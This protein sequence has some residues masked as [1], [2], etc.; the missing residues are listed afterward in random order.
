MRRSALIGAAPAFGRVGTLLAVVAPT[1]FG[2]GCS[3]PTT[4]TSDPSLGTAAEHARDLRTERDDFLDIAAALPG[5]AGLSFRRDTVVIHAT[6][7]ADL[8][9][10]TS[11]ALLLSVLAKRG[12]GSFA[13]RVERVPN[14]Y[15]AL[16]ATYRQVLGK[17][18]SAMTFVD[19]SAEHNRVRVGVRDQL[20]FPALW[21]P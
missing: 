7:D 8:A 13:V 12:V 3:E 1:L 20:P 2:A 21:M 18:P 16:H 4:S 5:F 15:R 6:A 9:G 14:D 17:A 10:A 19:I 11:N